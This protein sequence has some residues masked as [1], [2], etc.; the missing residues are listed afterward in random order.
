MPS[1]TSSAVSVV[2]DFLD[3]DHAV[4]ADLL[5]GV[6]D[7]FADRR[8]VVRGDRADLR[9]FLSRLDRTGQRACRASIG[10]LGRA[11]QAALEVDRAGTGDDVAH[12]VR[13]DR[14]RQNR[15]GAGAVA[16][17]IAGLLGR[18][19]QHLGAEVLLGILE[20][21]FLGDRGTPSL[22]TIGCTPFSLDQHRFRSR[23]ERNAD[24]VG[25]LGRAAQDFF[26]RGGP[27]Q[28]LF[29]RGHWITS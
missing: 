28:D 21:E 15:R 25:E 16:D 6:G 5:H 20:V 1:T 12:A 18:L 22:Q 24:R 13:K 19:T 3:G 2:F 17:H 27:E 7:E 4:A 11:I 10:A 9:L 29:C 23:T 14:V 26:A 8:V